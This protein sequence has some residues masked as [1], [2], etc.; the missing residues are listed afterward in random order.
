M[1][2][3]KSIIGS[4]VLLAFSACSD[5]DATSG[6]AGQDLRSTTFVVGEDATTDNVGET[7]PPEQAGTC[8]SH[9][10]KSRIE[11]DD[12]ASSLWNDLSS[13]AMY[14]TDYEDEISIDQVRAAIDGNGRWDT[15]LFG[16][17]ILEYMQDEGYTSYSRDD[18]V[19]EIRLGCADTIA[20][21]SSDNAAQAGAGAAQLSLDEA[22]EYF[23]DPLLGVYMYMRG[24]N[25]AGER[26][27]LCPV[28]QQGELP[29]APVVS[30]ERPADQKL[31]VLAQH[32]L[33]RTLNLPK[34]GAKHH[35][36]EW[37]VKVEL[38]P[39]GANTLADAQKLAREK[40]ASILVSNFYMSADAGAAPASEEPF[41]GVDVLDPVAVAAAA[42]LHG[43]MS[44]FTNSD[45]AIVRDKLMEL[46][47]GTD[48]AAIVSTLVD[49]AEL[50]GHKFQ[51]E[52]MDYG[53]EVIGNAIV[54]VTPSGGT[55][56]LLIHISYVHA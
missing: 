15:K 12:F 6:S 52:V 37:S 35:P 40:V 47:P 39:S 17:L 13:A 46:V 8:F 2:L 44:A 53:A 55:H 36:T 9:A 45:D 19:T 56:S 33:L 23:S 21:A 30:S 29:E 25:P 32:L 16:A 20:V 38:V 7:M 43:A 54:L 49:D 28:P 24:R 5:S 48:L 51:F 34:E 10:D 18:L 11:G 41:N 14:I 27:G 42:E 3:S 26:Y 22:R 1:K 4:G 31:A 50:D